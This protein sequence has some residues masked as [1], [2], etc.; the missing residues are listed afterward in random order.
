MK[1]EIK[2]IA[3]VRL[4]ALGD[5]VN[6]AVVLQFIK[7]LYPN[8]EIDWITEEVFAPILK[9]N[10]ELNMVHTVNIKEIKKE[11]SFSKLKALISKLRSLPK[12][13]LVIDMQ[14]LIKSAIV[15]RI[16]SKNTHGFNKYSTRES[17][18]SLFYKT[19]SDIPYEYNVVKRNCFV[20]AD[21]LDFSIT[22]TMLLE[23]KAVFPITNHYTL[24]KDKKNIAFVIGASWPSKIYPKELVAKICESLQEQVYIIWGNEQEKSE[25]EWICEQTEY[26]TLAPKMQLDELVSFISSVDL[27]IGN[28]TGPTHIA[29]AQNIPSITLLGP[30]TKRMI[31]ETPKNI[32]IKSSSE[33]DI[34]K[35]NKDDY[36]IKDIP[37]EDI[38]QT[39]KDLLCKC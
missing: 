34:L 31:Y 23:K 36:S 27:L 3:I 10:P 13:D 20:V 28:D 2:K 38:V 22:D 8:V 24:M 35:I 37:Y 1:Q 32:G 39:A 12:Y 17:L 29:W 5:I 11:K 21:A 4:S 6:S 18:A 30:T 33:V 16:V 9:H 15:A 25:A 19:T 14:G 26:A 7:Q